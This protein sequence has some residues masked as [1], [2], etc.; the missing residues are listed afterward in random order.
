MSNT[1]SAP[2][3]S[4]RADATTMGVVALA[5]GTSHFF[6][7]VLPTVFPWL[8]KDFGL[9]FAQLGSVATVF[10]VI[11]ATGQAMAGFLVD[12]IGA[13]PVM[14]AGLFGFAIASFTAATAQS[15]VGLVIASAIAG[16]ANSPFHPIDFSILNQRISS[17]RI[18]HAYSVHG[19]SGNLGWAFSA[20]FL[21]G[22]ASAFTWRV[23][24]ASAGVY[25]LVVLAVCFVFRDS[26]STPTV[27][28]TR[29]TADSANAAK[30]ESAL[31]FLKLPVVWV[32][33]LFFFVLTFPLGAVQNFSTPALQA[34][35]NVPLTTAAAALSGYMIVGAMGQVLGGFA[36]SRGWWDPDKGVAIALGI[37]AFTLA[38]AASAFVGNF[39]A[40]VLVALVVLSGF[41]VGMAAPSRDL[42]IKRATPKGATGRVYGAVYSGLDVGLAVAPLLFG[43]LMD[44]HMPRGVF[45]GASVALV[46]AIL[47][48]LWVGRFVKHARG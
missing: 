28:A 48:G 19:I 5:H 31:A 1:L 6:Q 35:A 16:F 2:E 3:S 39:S 25:A 44:H 4:F 12:R 17:K 30:P 9:T 8:A 22:L 23:A 18:G 42:L 40:Y 13:R 24:V 41:G 47:T 37:S 10:F 46:F 14:F 7:I 43:Y 36:V 20:V 29:A 33:W 34:I 11:S 32:C 21:V 27:H 26:L 45:A 38:L 15:Y